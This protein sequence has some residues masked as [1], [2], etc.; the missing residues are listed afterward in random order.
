M[1]HPTLGCHR[2]RLNE[3][4]VSFNVRNHPR[5]GSEPRPRE[6]SSFRSSHENGDIAVP[7]GLHTESVTSTSSFS[8]QST[9]LTR[10]VLHQAKTAVFSPVS[11]SEFDLG[12][13]SVQ[14]VFRTKAAASSL[15]ARTSWRARLVSLLY[16]IDSKFT[17]TINS[18]EV[19]CGRI[20]RTP[21]TRHILSGHWNTPTSLALE[22]SHTDPT[23]R[24]WKYIGT[25]LGD[26]PNIYINILC[27]CPSV[28]TRSSAADRPLARQRS[29]TCVAWSLCRAVYFI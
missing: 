23:A 20:F 7:I 19:G 16:E 13:Y 1:A 14:E 21:F 8:G 18:Y 6:S 4:S 22:E 28:F 25:S 17:M 15:R 26:V 12:S 2:A 3:I 10:C 27:Q 9:N 5:G 29:S 11:F 24:E